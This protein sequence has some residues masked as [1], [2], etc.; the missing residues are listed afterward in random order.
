[1]SHYYSPTWKKSTKQ[2]SEEIKAILSYEPPKY[3]PD[4]GSNL[5]LFPAV[6]TTF[7]FTINFDAI[8]NF[9]AYDFK[10]IKIDNFFEERNCSCKIQILMA[11]GCQCGGV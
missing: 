4:F 5:R 8:G 10:T 1:M 9:T 2:L 11:H 6:P 3:R 7:T